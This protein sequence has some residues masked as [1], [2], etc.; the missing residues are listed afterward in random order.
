MRTRQG[1]VFSSL[2]DGAVLCTKTVYPS[3]M[4][5]MDSP[6]EELGVCVMGHWSRQGC[7]GNVFCK[8]QFVLL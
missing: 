4:Y 8:N 7:G 5:V 3:C 1:G 2:S 6:D